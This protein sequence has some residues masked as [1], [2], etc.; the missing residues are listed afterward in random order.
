MAM[1]ETRPSAPEATPEAPPQ[2]VPADPAGL[3]GWFSTSDH[4]RVGRLWIATSLLFLLVGGVLVALLGIEGTKSGLD[5]FDKSSFLQ[6]STLSTE[7]LVLLFLA[8]LFLGIATFVVPLQVGSPEI[9]FPRG[10]ATAYWLYL[11][12]AGILVASYLADG[13]PT[14]GSRDA[15]DLWLLALA[16]VLVALTI[17][18][19]SVLTT[20]LAMR[21]PGMTLLRA[22]AFTWSTVVGG[23]LLLLSI[24]VLVAQLAD[25]YVSHHFGG[26]FGDYQRQIGWMWSIPTV[27][28]LAVGAVG[29]ALEI[30]PVLGRTQIKP[31]AAMVVLVGLLGIVGVGAWA[32]NE[33]TFDDL[34]YVAIGL[35]AV[36]P[37]LG[38]LGLVGN[39][40]RSGSP[41]P[42]AALLFAVGTVLLLL[43][44]AVAGA[45][46]SIDGLHLHNTTWELGQTHLIVLGA[47]TVGG[48][49]A[50]WWWAPKLWGVELPESAGI[51]AFLA[52]FGG[53]VLLA[54]G[55]LVNGLSNDLPLRASTFGDDSV[56]VLNGISAAGG[57]LVTLAGL[58]VVLV[59]LGAARRRGRVVTD[60]NPWGGYTLEWATTSPPPPANFS[61]PLPV[62][63]SATPLLDEVTA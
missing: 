17:G 62:I 42:K 47:G 43:L 29:V 61:A 38:L 10:S 37:A 56:K 52:S 23:S 57:V 63:A 45:L 13:G 40:L 1:T 15:A 58:L 11:V 16:G 53:A 12:S 22:P 59:L 35:A 26:D 20:A 2:L 49:G 31:H 27:Y 21:A 3:A 36:L 34:L 24:P 28:L 55:E 14:G 50:L 44:G 19:V 46:E 41:A 6:A 60:D 4:K 39:T 30:V 8:P 5:I 54:A 7:A 33:V 9:A 18:L 48:L 25:M 32:Q 51:L